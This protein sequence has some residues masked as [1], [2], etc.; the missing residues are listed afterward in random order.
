MWVV[1]SEDASLRIHGLAENRCRF[2]V[3]VFSVKGIDDVVESRHS[4]RVVGFSDAF[5]NSDLHAAVRDST[6]STPCSRDSTLS[7][8]GEL[9]LF[10][11]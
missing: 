9:S 3:A 2:G 10:L 8:L 7:H 5:L 4:V 6:F 1:G 11:N